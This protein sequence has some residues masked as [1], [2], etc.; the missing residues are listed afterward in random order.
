MQDQVIVR[1]A[2]GLESLVQRIVPD[3]PAVHGEEDLFPGF[4]LPEGHALAHPAFDPPAL[5]VVGPQTLYVV[6][7]P[8][9][10]AEHI[11]LPH[12]SADLVKA[13]DQFAVGHVFTS[14]LFSNAGREAHT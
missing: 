3:R 6:F 12:V 10:E 9:L 4:V 8:T 14:L 1:E 2:L 11:N 5:V 13:L 7:L